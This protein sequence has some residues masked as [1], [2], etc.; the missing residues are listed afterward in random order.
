MSLVKTK[1]TVAA[2]AQTVVAQVENQHIEA[3]LAEHGNVLDAPQAGVGDAVNQHHSSAGAVQRK[4]G[5]AQPVAEWRENDDF[6]LFPRPVVGFVQF[7]VLDFDLVGFQVGKAARADGALSER[8]C[9]RQQEEYQNHQ[10]QED[11]QHEVILS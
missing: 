5:G 10:Q 11:N 9:N 1:G 3:A 4:V 6:L 8:C 7:A 2:A